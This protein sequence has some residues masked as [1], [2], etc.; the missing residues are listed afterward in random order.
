MGVAITV[1]ERFHECESIQPFFIG[2]EFDLLLSAIQE[3]NS[4]AQ[5][6][7]DEPSNPASVFLWDQANNVFYLSGDAHN[8]QFNDEIATLLEVNVIPGLKRRRRTYFRLRTTS[9]AWDRQVPHIFK[10]TSLKKGQ[11]LLYAFGGHVTLHWKDAIPEGFDLHRIDDVL[12]SSPYETIGS[13]KREI[14]SMWP[15]IAR[16]MTHG[17]GYA[18]V[19]R[20]KI[21]SWCTSEYM[22]KRQCGIGIE[23]LRGYQNRGLATILTSAFVERCQQ[24]N[25]EPRWECSVDNRA[26]KRVAAKVGFVQARTYPI[27]YGRFR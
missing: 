11:Y 20:G 2:P 9:T 13:V 16:F 18:F 26:S 25:I 15:S 14:R 1:T 7:T 27:Y 8:R 21:V 23:T 24:N 17:F 22:S 6:W 10:T 4:P 12:M 5:I 19:I 3:C